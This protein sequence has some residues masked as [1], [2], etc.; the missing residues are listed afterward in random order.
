MLAAVNRS[1]SDGIGIFSHVHH[2]V[3]VIVAAKGW[4]RRRV[5]TI[6][7]KEIKVGS[8]VSGQFLLPRVVAGRYK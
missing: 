8:I 5:R 1:A 7:N 4:N 3:V 6:E 2:V